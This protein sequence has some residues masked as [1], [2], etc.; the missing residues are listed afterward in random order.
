MTNTSISTGLH[1][2]P[3]GRHSL[4]EAVGQIVELH[5]TFGG[6]A[7]VAVERVWHIAVPVPG[8]EKGACHERSRRLR[9]R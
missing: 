7:Q 8:G 3:T 4:R 9:H 2:G 1:K 6:G 5:L